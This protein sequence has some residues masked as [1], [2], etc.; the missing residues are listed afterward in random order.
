M[1]SQ[2][3][4]KFEIKSANA[5]NYTLNSVITSPRNCMPHD[6]DAACNNVLLESKDT[7]VPAML[8]A[9]AEY[10]LTDFFSLA[11]RTGLY[12]RQKLLWEAFGRV[13][14]VEVF[15]LQQGFFTKTDLP[16][17]DFH[18]IDGRGKVLFL[19]HFVEPQAMDS[20]LVEERQLKDHMRDLLHR[21]EKLSASRGP[22][23]GIFLYFCAP[24]PKI[25]LS[26][27]Q[28]LTGSSDP[29]GRYESLLPPPLLAPLDLVEVGVAAKDEADPA[30]CRFAFTLVQPEL[31]TKA[32]KAI[33]TTI[34]SSHDANDFSPD[35]Q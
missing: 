32:G 35:A 27:V 16:W 10:P 5:A 25:V 34:H 26:K 2:P 21:A 24:F 8:R 17:Y 22:L 1:T 18:F 3:A 15:K 23:T 28:E 4:F 29:V 14:S 13:T 31:G 9:C 7:A 30:V 19:A 12:N 6:L 11:H 20:L 33:A